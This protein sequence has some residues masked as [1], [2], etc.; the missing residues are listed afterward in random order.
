MYLLGHLALGYFSA[1]FVSYFTKEDTSLLIIVI[2]SL[3]PDLDLIIPQ[4][5][6]RG[7]TH[8]I[9]VITLVSIPIIFWYKRGFSYYAAL[10][11]HPLLGDYL[12]GYGCMLFWPI[13]TGFIKA[14][15]MYQI[16]RNTLL[17]FEILIFSAMS[18]SILV[19]RLVLKRQK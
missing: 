14:P 15:P 9:I 13:S 7:P 5:I 4:I 17:L 18:L 19:N 11:S 3:L 1:V 10:I 2:M 8:S 12:T 16:Q 6:H